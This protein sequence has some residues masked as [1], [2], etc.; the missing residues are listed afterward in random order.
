[1]NHLFP[2]VLASIL[3]LAGVYS[4]FAIYIGLGRV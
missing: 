1:M 4:V 2:V 3:F